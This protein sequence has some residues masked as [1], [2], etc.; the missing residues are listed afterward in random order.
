M[1]TRSVT[2]GAGAPPQAGRLGRTGSGRRSLPRPA[3]LP[4]GGPSWPVVV[5]A[6]VL[7]VVAPGLS[8]AGAALL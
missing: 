7:R 5:G 2:A 1:T 6:L 8:G 3:G 4:A